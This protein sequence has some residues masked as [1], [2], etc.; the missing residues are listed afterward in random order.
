MS[1]Y[2]FAK[3]ATS[4]LRSVS[5]AT[6]DGGTAFRPV[7]GALALALA[8]LVLGTSAAHA[9]SG[10]A[11]EGRVEITWAGGA[12]T[13]ALVPGEAARAETVALLR[14]A[15][16]T[17]PLRP[18]FVQGARLVALR[19]VRESTRL[20]A[21][22]TLPVRSEAGAIVQPI[23]PMSTDLPFLD[24][25]AGTGTV[26]LDHVTDNPGFPLP[27]AGEYF[28]PKP[29]TALERMTSPGCARATYDEEGNEL[30][31]ASADPPL[32]VTRERPAIS[33]RGDA[34]VP[35]G[36]ALWLNEAKVRLRREG[37]TWRGT[38]SGE[39]EG[40]RTSIDL[41]LR[42]TPKGLGALCRVPERQVA[43]ARSVAAA[44]RLLRRAGF[45]GA[46][47]AGRKTSS[48]SRSPR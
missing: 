16:M 26:E 3:F 30:S 46:R 48:S 24:L 10:G 14:T 4:K 20:C 32:D 13:V 15:R 5:V 41:V 33:T 40:V 23:V 37:A 25:L 6:W 19:A 31:P 27:F 42:G 34:L 18:E 38:A 12:A 47:A 36:Y 28:L 22:G 9:A 2:S 21:G 45:P 35:F 29:P 39:E 7:R 44:L 1:G 17:R 8:L 43:R 11:A